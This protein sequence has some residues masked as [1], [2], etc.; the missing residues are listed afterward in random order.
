MVAQGSPGCRDPCTKL[1]IGCCTQMQSRGTSCAPSSAMQQPATPAP[2]PASPPPPAAAPPRTH[3]RRRAPAWVASGMGVHASDTCCNEPATAL[4][5][6]AF[7]TAR[8]P[9]RRSAHHLTWPCEGSTAACTNT[10]HTSPIL[11]RMIEWCS[12]NLPAHLVIGGVDAGRRRGAALRL[13]AREDQE[14]V[15]QG[16]GRLQETGRRDGMPSPIEASS[17]QCGGRSAVL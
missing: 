5:L 3:P 8:Q 9:L 11:L 14:G 4:C 7:L 10:T 6:G 15:A 13:A 1:V 16:A 12:I 17:L 2:Q